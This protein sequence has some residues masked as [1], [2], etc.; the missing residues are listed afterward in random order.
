[1]STLIKGLIYENKKTKKLLHYLLKGSIV[2]L[3]HE[4]LDGV[5]VD[6]LIE[7]KVKAVINGCDSMSGQYVHEHV[8][9]LLKAGIAVF[10]IVQLHRNEKRYNGELVHIVENE[11]FIVT[12]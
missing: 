4:D 11:L 9:T 8:R 12:N 7:A 6:G 3:W 10:D 2:F 5:A 1:M